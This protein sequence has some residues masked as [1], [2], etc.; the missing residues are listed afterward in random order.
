M[1]YNIQYIYIYIYILYTYMYHIRIHTGILASTD[2]CIYTYTYIPSLH[3]LLL[4]IIYYI[5]QVLLHII[6]YIKYTV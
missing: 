3:I 5:I 2:Q 6:Y 4:H 1:L